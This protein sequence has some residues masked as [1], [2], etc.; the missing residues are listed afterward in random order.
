MKKRSLVF[1]LIVLLLMCTPPFLITASAFDLTVTS[2][3]CLPYAVISQ[4]YYY[5]AKE[6]PVILIIAGV[7]ALS[8]I[9]LWFCIGKTAWGDLT[10]SIKES[11]THK[12]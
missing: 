7:L 11:Y 10:K 1:P 8:Q 12:K 5:S 2:L 3:L 9:I 4:G 6:S